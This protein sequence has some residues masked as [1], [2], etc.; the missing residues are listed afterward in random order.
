M[1]LPITARASAA[2][3][4]VSVPLDHMQ[5]NGPRFA[6]GYGLLTQHHPR[7]PTVF[8]V[9]DG[10]QFYV[11]PQSFA[12]SVGP[13]FDDRVNVVGIFGRADA[14]AVQAA[15]GSGAST[16]WTQ[17][18][19][20]LR[21]EQWIG[22]L[23][24]VR[25]A[26]LGPNGRIGLYGRSGGAF[27]VHQYMAVHGRH[28]DRVFTQAAV[29]P[30]LEARLGVVA[31][32][33]W[34]ELD[35][36]DRTRLAAV[37]ADGRYPRARVATLFQRQNF[38]VPRDQL[39]AER[40]MLIGELA[41][42]AKDRIATREQTY[43]ID[44]LAKLASGPRGPA[45]NVRLFEFFVPRAVGFQRAPDVLHPDLE[46]FAQQ[47]E[48]L[49]ALL[50]Q[51]RI[52]A[53]TMAFAPLHALNAEVLAVAGRWD[54]TCDY[55]TQIALAASYPRGTLLLLDDDHVFHRLQAA[56]G[57]GPLVRGL[58]GGAGSDEYRTALQA[59]AELRWVEE[60]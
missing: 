25:R 5:P 41:D 27:L 31:D 4:T 35:A 10:Q 1:T 26:L 57:A 55:R 28:V 44:A 58:F 19:R 36:T 50:Q 23:E 54:H 51:G 8:V 52:A 49:I 40:R 60:A 42:N 30:F 14:P 21:A 34:A 53:P 3:N 2:L 59:V 6:L 48:P 13:L 16:D 45:I 33:F 17:A 29:N 9:A 18:H 12:T 38:F 46:V 56:G 11:T 24:A 15:V 37:L 32:R 43:Q 22:D 20:L 39:A 47:A 7:R